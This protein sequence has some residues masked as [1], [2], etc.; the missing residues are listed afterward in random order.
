MALWDSFWK[1]GPLAGTELWTLEAGPLVLLSGPGIPSTG[2]QW[3]PH[4]RLPGQ[5]KVQ[6]HL[7]LQRLYPARLPHL[8]LC[9]CVC[10]C[11]CVLG[12]FSGK[13]FKTLK[14][15]PNPPLKDVNR[16][17]AVTQNCA[18][19]QLMNCLRSQ[20]TYHANECKCENPQQNTAK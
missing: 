5:L 15:P 20:L 16:L 4:S 3:C 13:V 17:G 12:R 8:P 14:L 11:V 6:T 10:L 19:R 18:P 7:P 9:S 2:G 1:T